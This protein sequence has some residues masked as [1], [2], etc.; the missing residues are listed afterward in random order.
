MNFVEKRKQIVAYGLKLKEEKLTSGTTGNLSILDRKTGTILI[1]PSGIPYDELKPEQIVEMDMEG[2]VKSGD[3]KPSSE[4]HLH[5]LLYQKRPDASAIVH[6]HS[7]YATAVGCMGKPLRAVHYLIACT[8]AD[9]VP[10]TPYR[11]YGT[12]ELARVTVENMTNCKAALMA[13]HGLIAYADSLPKAFRIAANCEWCA[14][15]QILCDSCGP[16]SVI[17][18]EEIE[19]TIRSFNGHSE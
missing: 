9:E 13:N 17:S 3:L 6:D 1:T 10:V 8:D 7:M 14:Q 15:L 19:R 12:E 2:N 16:A 4:Y 18:K 5:T 11:V